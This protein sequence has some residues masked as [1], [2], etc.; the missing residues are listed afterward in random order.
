M[1]A[2]CTSTPVSSTAPGRK[3]LAPAL[4]LGVTLATASTTAVSAP[5]G[6]GVSA[7]AKPTTRGASTSPS[8]VVRATA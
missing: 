4:T 8:R 7:L 2:R 3:A 6:A 1:P 5:K